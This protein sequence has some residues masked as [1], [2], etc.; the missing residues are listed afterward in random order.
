MLRRDGIH[1]CDATREMMVTSEKFVQRWLHT[2][3][4]MMRGKHNTC[5]SERKV[6]GVYQFV[7]KINYKSQ[8]SA[9]KAAAKLTEKWGRPMDAYRCW[10]CKGWHIGNSAHLTF[11]KF[12]SILWIWVIQKKRTTP[13]VR[14]WEKPNAD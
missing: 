4:G 3:V 12:W 10:F 1:Y 9:A 11:W 2:I 8:P 13:K 7:P 5:L 6:D 14:P